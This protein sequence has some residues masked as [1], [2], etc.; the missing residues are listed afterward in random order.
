MRYSRPAINNKGFLLLEVMV[1]IV[2]IAAGLVFVARSYSSSRRSVERS[3]D[4]IRA[5]NLMNAKFWEFEQVSEV[6]EGASG[7]EIEGKEGYSWKIEAGRIADTELNIVR[8]GIYEKSRPTVP[9][10]SFFT[11][12]RNKKD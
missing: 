6:K 5:I 8:L 7:G 1:A 2:I 3:S 10:Y 11:Y 4:V 9:A 12:L